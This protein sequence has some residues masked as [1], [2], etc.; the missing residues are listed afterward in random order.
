MSAALPVLCICGPSAAGKT[1]FALALAE[2]LRQGGHQPLLITCDNYYRQG[3]HPHPRFGFDTLAAI[4]EEALRRDVSSARYGQADMLRQYDM[5]TRLVT[6]HPVTTPYDM[7]LLEGAYGPQLLQDFPLAGLLY[8]ETP[9]LL[10]LWRRLKRDVRERQRSPLYVIRQMLL[11]MLLRYG[12]P[13]KM[14]VKL[15]SARVDDEITY[16]CC[17]LAGKEVHHASEME[18]AA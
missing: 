18:T 8:V 9:L 4:D 6:C 15:H 7:V 11:Q 16:V 12:D 13:S 3:W 17:S 5:R 14:V 1:T 2:A 10:R